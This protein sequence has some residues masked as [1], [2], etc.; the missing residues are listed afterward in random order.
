MNK[1]MTQATAA[2][3]TTAMKNVAPRARQ[4]VN[5]ASL[6]VAAL[7]EATGGHGNDRGALR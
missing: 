6:S 4:D 1:A 2:T 7:R 5:V 3:A